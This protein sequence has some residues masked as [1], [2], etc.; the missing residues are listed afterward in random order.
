MKNNLQHYL[1]KLYELKFIYDVGEHRIVS[2][3][4]KKDLWNTV[5]GYRP[6]E[7]EALIKRM[8]EELTNKKS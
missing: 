1:D 7:T 2:G 8:H 6:I 5:V 3:Q 4:D